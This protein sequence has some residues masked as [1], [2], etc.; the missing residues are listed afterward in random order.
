VR[1]VNVAVQKETERQKQL[2]FLQITANPIDAP[3]VGELG[4]A[5]VLRSVAT[6][7]GLP[8]D[9]VPDDQTLQQMIQAKQQMQAAGQ[10]MVAAAGGQPGQPGAPGAPGQPG[11]PGK[12]APASPAAAAQGAQV[13]T[14]ASAR[15]S[16]NA[17]P[18]NSFSQGITP[19]G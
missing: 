10:A 4:R 11:P 13:P 5:R 8:D 7:L 17:P 16:D 12:S 18:V 14:P 1:G 3:I 15:L 6:G 2:Q 9:I 19:N